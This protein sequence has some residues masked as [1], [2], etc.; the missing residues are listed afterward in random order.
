MFLLRA[1]AVSFL[2]FV[3]ATIAGTGYRVYQTLT[4]EEFSPKSFPDLLRGPNARELIN[5]GDLPKQEIVQGITLP[6]AVLPKLTGPIPI[7]RWECFEAEDF[8]KSRKTNQPIPVKRCDSHRLGSVGDWGFAVEFDEDYTGFHLM[9]RHPFRQ[10]DGITKMPAN[11]TGYSLKDSEYLYQDLR[12]FRWAYDVSGQDRLIMQTSRQHTC[13]LTKLTNNA[14]LIS[15]CEG[16]DSRWWSVFLVRI[17]S[18]E[19]TRLLEYRECIA[20]NKGA[21]LWELKDCG[22]PFEGRS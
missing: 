13:T 12:E 22:I 2:L 5:A 18:P 20:V 11:E 3:M 9:M 10:K 1:L 14:L 17:G 15:D 4:I 8:S 7:G 16:R 19:Y 6:N 21:N